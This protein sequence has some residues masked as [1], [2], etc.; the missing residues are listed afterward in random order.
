MSDTHEMLKFFKLG[1]DLNSQASELA[2]KE[3]GEHSDEGTDGQ[4]A[5][6]MRPQTSMLALQQQPVMPQVKPKQGL[7]QKAKSHHQRVTRSTNS[8]E[9]FIFCFLCGFMGTAVLAELLL[10]FNVFTVA[11][12]LLSAVSVCVMTY[13]ATAIAML[14][15]FP[16]VDKHDCSREDNAV[17]QTL[18]HKVA[19]QPKCVPSNQLQPS[20][21]PL[22]GVKPAIP[23]AL[24]KQYD[25]EPFN[26]NPNSVERSLGKAPTQ[27]VQ[28]QGK[29]VF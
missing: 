9:L 6:T 3:S 18:V 24:A 14:T 5:L 26:P 22:L 8:E 4:V 16:K 2:D 1:H 7:Q 15:L 13:A 17:Q 28:P 29:I 11:T 19:S 20:I 21:K 12:V 10:L 27:S 25:Y 23:P